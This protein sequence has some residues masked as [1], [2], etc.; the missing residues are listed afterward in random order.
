[1]AAAAADTVNGFNEE[2][3]PLKNM[4][5]Y[6]SGVAHYEHEGIVRGLGKIKWLK[7]KFLLPTRLQ[8]EF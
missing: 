4:T 6:S 5:L 7:L 3:I 1:M 8:V 2:S